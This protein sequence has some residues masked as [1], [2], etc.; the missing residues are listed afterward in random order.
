MSFKFPIGVGTMVNM[1]E[2]VA[3]WIINVISTLGYPG[4]ILTMAIESMLI[5]LPSEVIMPF[6]GFLA[7]TG[8][9][10]LTLVILSGA[11]G[12]T[13]G[14]WVAYGL[15]LWGHDRVVRRFVRRYGKV[16]LLSETELD[17][18][19]AFMHKYKG[20]SVLIARFTPGVRTIISLPAGIARLPFLRFTF[21]TFVGTLLWSALLAWIGYTLGTNWKSLEVYFRKFEIAIIGLIILAIAFYVFRKLSK[22]SFR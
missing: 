16:I 14:S 17:K 22:K 21:L 1:L 2:S 12:N 6:S 19:E 3:G 18:M 15:G 8:R 13:I 7:S 4:I 20:V 5:P 11:V 9:F 10:D